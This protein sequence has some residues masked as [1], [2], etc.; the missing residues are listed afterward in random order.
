MSKHN[1]LLQE[2]IDELINTDKTLQGPLMKLNYF[3][4]LTKNQKLIDFT[5]KEMK[6]YEVEDEVPKYRET[7]AKLL[8]TAQS[9]YVDSQELEIPISAIKELRNRFTY[10]GV[11]DGIATVE[12]MAR[13]MEEKGNK[14]FYKPLPLELLHFVQPV[15]REL[16]KTNP[17][18]SATGSRLIGNGNIFLDIPSSI[19]TTLLELVMAIADE[20]GYD[21]EISEFNNTKINNTINNYMSTNITNTGDGNVINTGNENKIS[22]SNSIRKGD[23]ESLKTELTKLGIDSEDVN[24]LAEIVQSESPNEDK[25]LGENAMNWIL[26]ISKKALNG[27]GKIATGVSSNLL[28]TLIKG[29]YEIN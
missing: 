26:N 18:L 9:Y 25:T 16:Y 10:V 17:P 21:V 29:Y 11:R 12:K 24:D 4:R 28:A 3:G 6:G 5:T 8:V 7:I 1:F 19:R 20:F 2:V 15:L 27:V 22:N 14:E 23:L 13:D